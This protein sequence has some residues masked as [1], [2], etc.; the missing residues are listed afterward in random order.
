MEPPETRYAKS[1][2]VHIAYQ[3]L[4]GGPLD[5]VFVPGAITNLDLLWE[6]PRQVRFN[7]RLAAFSRLIRFDKRGTGLSDRSSGIATL[8][9]RMDDVRAVMDA[10]GSQRAAV[11]GSSEGGAMA[12]LFAATYPERTRAL[13]LYAT[14]A[15]YPGLVRAP[16]QLEAAIARIERNWGTGDSLRRMA[17]SLAHDRD[18]MRAWA[19]FE[20]LSASPATLIALRQMN[21]DIDIR[22]VLPVI[23][24]PTLV[25]HRSGDLAISVEAG[26]Y[27]GEHIPGAKYVELPGSDHFPFAGDSERLVDEIEEFLTG[28]RSEAEPDRVLVTV[29]FTD[30][31]DSTRRAAEL[32]DRDWRR[33]LD[34]HDEMARQE[35]ARFRGRAVKSLGDGFLATFDGPARA[36]RCAAAI[37]ERVR[38]LGIA[39]RSGLHTG[40]IEL[41]P[42]DIAGIAVHTA[43]RVSELAQS[44]EVLVSST[45]RDLVAG[46]GLQFQDRG[47]HA[48]RGLPEDV[49]LYSALG[50]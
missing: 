6:N 26:R 43:A 27:L 31:V 3:V 28:S 7:V 11:L 25:L 39:V 10:V 16:G 13:V 37:A 50:G 44:G 5:L 19:R 30:I 45:V 21:W 17:P 12:I 20:R 18:A 42:E 36:V 8:E 23:R 32:G 48:L 29:L 24:V 1:G 9:E 38:P 33:L 15:Q 47:H 49:H 40:E 46:S 4:G 34:R 41:M 22:H 2:D 35:I 14:F